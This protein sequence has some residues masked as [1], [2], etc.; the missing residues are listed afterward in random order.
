MVYTADFK[1]IKNGEIWVEELKSKFTSK[2]T[3]YR[4]RIKLFLYKYP[5]V[6]FI[7]TIK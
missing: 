5:D 1:Y 4:I 6:N 3:D 2:L 7:E